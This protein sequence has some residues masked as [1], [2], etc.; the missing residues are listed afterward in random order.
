MNRRKFLAWIVQLFSALIAALLALPVIRFLSASAG[1]E[2]SEWY[3]I[4][5][6]ASITEE[7]S[8]ISFTRN[9]RDG[10]LS[11]DVQEFVWVRKK[12]D[13]S[14]VVYEPHCTHL[15][16]AY[17]WNPQKREF[18]CPCH[19]GKFNIN[20]DK[21]AGPPPRPLDRY[22]T[23]VEGGVLKIGKQVKA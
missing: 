3:P 13:G 10:W 11:R 4:A 19:G 21:I 2:D 7:I 14:F 15:G 9:V 5:D 8:N 6:A 22:M 20:G 1:E 23:R 17:A 18:D 12:P 16:C